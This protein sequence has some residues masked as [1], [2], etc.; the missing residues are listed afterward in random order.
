MACPLIA[1]RFIDFNCDQKFK[2]AFTGDSIARGVGDDEN[3][4]NGG[5][6][7]RVRKYVR[8]LKTSNLGSPGT[9]AEELLRDFRR[10]IDKRKT[11]K[12]LADVDI[13]FIDVGRNDYWQDTP[14]LSVVRNIK[15]TIRFL[16]KN[17]KAQTGVRPLFVVST[18]IP[19]NRS[20]QQPY[21]DEINE[22][23]VRFKANDLPVELLF[24]E[25]FSTSILSFD[26]L[27]PDGPGYE[28]LAQFISEFL[29]NRAQS[30]QSA[31][32]RDR[33][34]DG[35]FD[36]FEEQFGTLKGNP[37]SDGDGI[38]DGEDVFG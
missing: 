22:A 1:K 3:N 4:D 38:L 11:S 37:D 30:I 33:D 16:Q 24:H 36:K 8:R 32:R 17:V 2:I 13:I 31:K 25:N 5:Y 28:S 29:K 14:A 27:H 9:T 35:I 20:F 23:L 6:V 10:N 34:N 12:R 18:L 19:T 15:R 7:K 26:D 21:V